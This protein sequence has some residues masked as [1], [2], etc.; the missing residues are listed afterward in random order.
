MARRRAA[1]VIVRDG[2]VL[3]VRERGRGP[4]GRHDGVEYWTLPGGGIAAGE[5]AQDAVVREVAEEVGLTAVSVRHLA[6][7]PFP[8]GPTTV[9]AVEVAPG[10]PVL[11]A[12]DYGCDC[13]MM[14]GLDWVPLPGVVPQSAGIPIAPMI[15][16]WPVG[17]AG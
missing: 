6:D 14:V 16:A 11:G 2:H 1:A 15:V 17:D 13:P 5:S 3:M 8:S 9:F 7:M 12:E 4:E 10:E